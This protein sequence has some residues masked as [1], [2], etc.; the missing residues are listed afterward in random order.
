MK[1][2]ATTEL[3]EKKSFTP[4]YSACEDSMNPNQA[5]GEDEILQCVTPFET[6]SLFEQKKAALKSIGERLLH[7]YGRHG[8][9]GI[10]RR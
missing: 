3:E 5:E 2:I 4:Y 1:A 9:E 6:G 10:D 8:E 7:I